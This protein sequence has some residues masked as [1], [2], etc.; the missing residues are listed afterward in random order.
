ML[1]KHCWMQGTEVQG[2]TLLV[3]DA[4]RDAT[5]GAH[6]QGVF[7]RWAAL[8]KALNKKQKERLLMPSRITVDRERAVFYVDF[9]T[10]AAD[11]Y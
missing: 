4:K 5:V 8:S 9:E 3:I 6:W 7:D 10:A 2:Q 1:H 11:L